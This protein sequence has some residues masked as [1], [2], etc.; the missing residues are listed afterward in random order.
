MKNVFISLL[1]ALL[2]LT[3]CNRDSP[4]RTSLTHDIII[5]DVNII[6]VASGDILADRTV[7]I[8]G[9]RILKIYKSN[10]KSLTSS[11]T[12]NGK[13]KFLIPGLWDMHIHYYW[14]YKDSAPY[15][16]ANG[17]VG[18]REMFG[19]MDAVVEMKSLMD[20]GSLLGPEIFSSGAIIDGPEPVWPGSDKVANAEDANRVVKEQLAQGVDFLKV[21]S[22]LSRESYL[23]IA[24]LAE[25]NKI[26]FAGHIP[27]K[28]T[29]W[30]AI[31]NNQK[32]IE[33]NTGILEAASFK[34]D[35]IYEYYQNTTASN[36]SWR[37]EM[38]HLLADTY[39]EKRMDSLISVL[40]SSNTWLCPTMVVMRGMAYNRDSTMV[41]DARQDNLPGYISRL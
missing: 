9:E 6:D 4:N 41:N 12:V 18:V 37:A 16:V 24:R 26:N 13:N 8:N 39:S 38:F 17:I 19:K 28:V 32:S 14:N 2:L 40:S 31:A 5:T 21:Y 23:T 36:A 34:A 20:N 27:Q 15:L 7:G 11:I 29:F 35:S 33:H 30:E 10:D 22:R 1:S 25:Q 3:S